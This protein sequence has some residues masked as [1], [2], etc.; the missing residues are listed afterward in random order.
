MRSISV[1]SDRRKKQTLKQT[2][3][4]NLILLSHALSH[5]TTHVTGT[6]FLTP[7]TPPPQQSPN[8]STSPPRRH[9]RH[10]R[11]R[12][13]YMLHDPH[14]ARDIG[15]SGRDAFYTIVPCRLHRHLV[16]DDTEERGDVANTTSSVQPATSARPTGRPRHHRA[17]LQP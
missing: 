17:H 15:K 3:R 16:T 7:P 9:R 14:A 5:V 8:L 4:T 1:D 2:N 12:R 10:Q 11:T 6:T 13:P